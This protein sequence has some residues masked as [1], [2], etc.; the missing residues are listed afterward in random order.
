MNV[1]LG[2]SR[3]SPQ[4]PWPILKIDRVDEDGIVVAVLPEYL[5]SRQSLVQ[6]DPQPLVAEDRVARALRPGRRTKSTPHRR[7]RLSAIT[8]PSAAVAPPMTSLIAPIATNTPKSAL[9][10]AAVRSGRCGSLSSGCYY[11]RR[12]RLP[13]RHSR[14]ITLPLNKLRPESTNTPPIPLP[15]GCVP[16]T[17]VPMKFPSM[18]S[19]DPPLSA[20]SNSQQVRCTRLRI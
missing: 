7:W 20:V 5:G 19:S 4:R 9:G 18:I 10:S 11:W 1:V 6:V 3:E 8:L 16:L 15:S 17:S 14:G 13:R 12:G 2:L